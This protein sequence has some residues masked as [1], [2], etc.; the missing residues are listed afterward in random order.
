MCIRDRRQLVGIQHEIADSA[1][2]PQ[3]RGANE[4]HAEAVWKF[5][6][7]A[8]ARPKPGGPVGISDILGNTIDRI[9]Y[10]FNAPE[11]QT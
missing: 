8:K 5:L 7:I 6:V 3:G 9:V 11:A 2:H 10:L 4:F 1:Y